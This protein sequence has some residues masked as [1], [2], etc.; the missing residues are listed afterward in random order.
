[1]TKLMSMFKVAALII[2]MIGGILVARIGPS[3]ALNVQVEGPTDPFE[4]VPVG[5]G[6][7]GNDV[8]YYIIVDRFCDGD[9][10]NN[11]PTYA[12]P[13]S[14][15]L[16][17]E[18]QSYNEMNR[19]LLRHT[20]DP[21]HRYIGMYWGGDLQGIIEKLD[22]LQDLG[23][24]KL[25][26]SP[27][28]DNANGLVYY[29]QSKG[30]LFTEVSDEE[31][32]DNLYAHGSSAFH[33]YWTKDWFEIDEH[34]RDPQ[35]QDRFQVFRELL[36][37]A[38][39]RDIGILLDL[40]LNHTSPFPYYQRPPEYLESSI[41]F[42]F[43]DNGSVY[44]HGQRVA[45]YWNPT[46]GELDQQNWFH[47]F[48]PIDFN[49]PNA[50]MLEEGTLPGGLPD[51]NQDVPA[52]EQYLL[53]ATRFWLTFNQ[54]QTPIA[55]FR[56]DAVKH[57]NVK[58]WNQFE[59]MVLSINPD[60]MLIGEYFSGGYRNADSINWLGQTKHYTQ[61]DFNLS[62]PARN[63]FVREREWDGR[64]FIL[65]EANLGRQGFFYNLKGPERW[66]H[67][68]L[69][70]AETL[71]IPREAL[72]QIPDHDAKGW[73]TFIEN[74]DEPRLMTHFP[75]TTEEAY[76]SLIK[77]MFVSRG[78][79]MLMYGV[80]TGL[81][82]PYHLQHSGLF[83]IGGDPF[84]RPMMI[85]PGSNG[86]NDHLYQVT[87]AMAHLR[88]DYP[89]L[90]FGEVQFLFPE[91]SKREDDI[92]MMRKD[93]SCPGGSCPQV[94]YAYSTYGGSYLVAVDDHIQTE[95]NAETGFKAPLMDGLLPIKLRAEEAKVFI[96]Q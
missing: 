65:R 92:F 31:P 44:R 49:R 34:F 75:D 36:N 79:P 26:L 89:V 27:I 42:W 78:V 95:I 16:S 80:E 3:S 60:A 8:L 70:P 96:L 84:N 74:H 54:E 71:E 19:L 12:F 64:T 33:G 10:G 17:Q 23:V 28:Q 21:S 41:G 1:M 58:F 52:V 69:D 77:F 53:D 14:P 37:E 22:Y 18:E 43:V 57:V 56:L 6:N 39:K 88:Q 13:S 61:F 86:W 94:L 81:A 9:I 73:V 62:M 4:S 50:R 68:L 2:L 67:K 32:R 38:G 85:W 29:P 87:R 25:I 66:I 91:D 20:H 11:V 47:P 45:T 63:F 46:T 83:G 15:G 93:P 82:V 72:D 90:R 24:T 55:G 76:A 59:D 48:M 51:L 35:G 5:K 40:T 30:Y 7:I